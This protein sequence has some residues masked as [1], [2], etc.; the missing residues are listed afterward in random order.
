MLYQLQRFLSV[1]SY[2]RMIEIGEIEKI[3]QDAVVTYLNALSK[4]NLKDRRII[5][6]RQS[7]LSEFQV[8]IRTVYTLNKIKKESRENVNGT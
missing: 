8:E 2:E 4:L 1:Q 7:E 5:E 6:Y 3:M